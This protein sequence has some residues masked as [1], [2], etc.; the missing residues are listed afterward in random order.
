MLVLGALVCSWTA[1]EIQEVLEA[2]P[3]KAV[4]AWIEDHLG[5]TVQSRRRTLQT[6]FSEP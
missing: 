5:V 4:Q 2:T 6:I 3:W 1:E